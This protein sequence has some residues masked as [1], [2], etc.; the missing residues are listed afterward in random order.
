VSPLT[1]DY[2]GRAALVTGAARGIGEATALAL[3]GAGF[4]VVVSD[5]DEEGARETVSQ[6]EAAGGRGAAI[7]TDVGDPEQVEAMVDFALETYGRLD[8]AVNNAGIPQ[9][10]ALT[11]PD[12][13]TIESMGLDEWHEL[14]R[15]NLHGAFY[16]TRFEIRAMRRNETGGSIVNLSSSGAAQALEGM[17]G[18]CAS[19]K[20]VIGLTETAAI[21]GAHHNIRVNTVLPGRARTKMNVE[22]MRDDD[23]EA[24]ARLD[25]TAPLNRAAL[26][27]E[28]ADAILWL[29]GDTSSYVTGHSLLVDGG[30]TIRHARSGWQ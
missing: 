18:Y 2:S 13:S 6:I 24:R 16:C 25:A 1:L 9:R 12:A 26:P 3:A 23:P 19:K 7:R 22:T 4:G 21:E 29:C 11:G 5:V 10:Y 27:S 28:L 30:T 20:G 14:V 15:V 8:A 17:G